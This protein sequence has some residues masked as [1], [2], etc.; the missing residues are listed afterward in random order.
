MDCGGRAKRRHRF[1][2]N[3]RSFQIRESI[4][5]AN[6]EAKAVSP[7]RSATAVHI[8]FLAVL[9]LG[10]ISCVHQPEPARTELDLPGPRGEGI[11]QLRSAIFR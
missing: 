9:A 2:H 7:L 8:G 1:G 5:A 4:A 3:V 11:V 6:G 10:L